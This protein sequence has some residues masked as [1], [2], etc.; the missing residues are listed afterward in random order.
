MRPTPVRRLHHEGSNM[1]YIRSTLAV[2]FFLAATSSVEAVDR[3]FFSP[4]IQSKMDAISVAHALFTARM[5]TQPA[6]PSKDDAFWKKNFSANYSDGVWAVTSKSRYSPDVAGISM[7][8]A[9][10]DGR[11]LG[12]VFCI[13]A[14][15][16]VIRASAPVGHWSNNR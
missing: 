5:R 10:Q 15:C 8:I 1:R 3:P 11:F 4:A 12:L 7:Q 14:G 2:T 13:R 9:A 16:P 6:A